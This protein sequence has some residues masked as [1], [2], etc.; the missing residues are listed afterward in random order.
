M[1][2]RQYAAGE[3]RAAVSETAVARW[4]TRHAP[5]LAGHRR[6]P[7]DPLLEVSEGALKDKKTIVMSSM[8]VIIRILLSSH[9]PK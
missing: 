7:V 4:P 3:S 5:G 9:L 6:Q 8:I 1:A 2:I